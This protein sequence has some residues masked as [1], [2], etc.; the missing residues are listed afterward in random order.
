M[1]ALALPTI[2]H[3]DTWDREYDY[4]IVG[5]GSAGSVLA[6]RLSE[7]PLI[8]VLLL[9]AGGS[10]NVVSDIPLAYMTMQQTPM[11]WAFT[12]EPQRAA[13]FGHKERV[14]SRGRIFVF[15]L[16]LL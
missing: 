12:T 13:C 7:N 8:R 5:A 14:S 15:E 3:R 2:T 16:V 1:Q 10:E 11:D 4:I 6:N 9:E